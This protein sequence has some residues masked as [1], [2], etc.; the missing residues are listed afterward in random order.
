[1][2]LYIVIY[3]AEALISDFIYFNDR[4]DTLFIES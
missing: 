3:G 4:D 2:I 1:M